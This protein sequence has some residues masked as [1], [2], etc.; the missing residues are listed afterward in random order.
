MSVSHSVERT[1]RNGTLNI[2]MYYEILFLRYY[3]WVYFYNL[4]HLVYTTTYVFYIVLCKS[5]ATLSC[6]RTLHPSLN[7]R[8][9]FGTSFFF[10]FVSF[11]FALSRPSRSHFTSSSRRDNLI[12][13]KCASQGFLHHLHDSASAFTIRPR[14]IAPRAT[15][16]TIS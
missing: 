5:S 16:R 10:L 3:F 6:Y 4:P 2:Y 1:S 13:F 8:S 12:R 14:I 9:Q 11:V 15:N 7:F